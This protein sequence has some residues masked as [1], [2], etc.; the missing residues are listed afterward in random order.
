M[1]PQKLHFLLLL[2]ALANPCAPNAH[3][4]TAPAE[5]GEI[6]LE[7]G[8]VAPALRGFASEKRTRR[9]LQKTALPFLRF[10]S[11]APGFYR[12]GLSSSGDK[13]AGRVVATAT[14]RVGMGENALEAIGSGAGAWPKAETLRP[15]PTRFPT[16][17]TQVYPR[18]TSKIRRF[19]KKGREIFPTLREQWEYD[20]KH[21]KS[22]LPIRSTPTILG[23]R[24]AFE[25]ALDAARREAEANLQT[26]L[27]QRQLSL[28]SNLKS[29][30]ERA[31]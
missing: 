2:L 5:F 11:G 8:S 13:R 29:G 16:E 12:L 30:K 26:A 21:D 3:A 1:K 9:E 28:Q 31:N 25:A 20:Q 15:L 23:A 14:I 22:G 19:D 10:R 7:N 17:Q 6:R 18:P 27:L 24:A 4:Q